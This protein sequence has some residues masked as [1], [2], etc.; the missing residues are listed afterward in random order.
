[1]AINPIQNIAV[2]KGTIISAASDMLFFLEN[3]ID[4]NP[5]YDT[6]NKLNEISN[7]SSSGLSI[8]LK[9]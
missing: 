6:V 4:N 5:I 9:P 3:S 8:F 7:F 2:E 1:M